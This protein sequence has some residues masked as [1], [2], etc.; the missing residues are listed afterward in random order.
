MLS[1]PTGC[2]FGANKTQR[3]AW[4]LIHHTPLALFTVCKQRRVQPQPNPS[5]SVSEHGLHPRTMPKR[6]PKR[7]VAGFP[8]Q[9]SVRD[10]SPLTGPH[11]AAVVAWLLCPATARRAFPV[12]PF[13]TDLRQTPQASELLSLSTNPEPRRDGLSPSAPGQGLRP[14]GNA[15]ASVGPGPPPGGVAARRAR[16][17][18]KIATAA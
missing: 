7:R 4:Q 9:V 17:R 16:F 15:P 12:G 3:N 6:P 18:E 11:F 1:L 5:Q 8:P 10:R 2:T 13:R 14:I